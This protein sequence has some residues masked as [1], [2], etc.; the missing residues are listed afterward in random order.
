MSGVV[1]VVLGVALVIVGLWTTSLWLRGDWDGG[2]R[3]H[4]LFVVL[5]GGLAIG[6]GAGL[7]SAGGPDRTRRTRGDEIMDRARRAH[8][9]AHRDAARRARRAA[10]R[11][12]WP[13]WL[14]RRAAG[15]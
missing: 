4:P 5:T 6:G 10:R 9:E 15:E 13:R 8:L 7:F 3:G 11:A 14:S 2:G 12:R 1:V